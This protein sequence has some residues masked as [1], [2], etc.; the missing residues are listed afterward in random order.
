[1]KNEK[2]LFQR[3][4]EIFSLKRLVW[5]TLISGLFLVFYTPHLKFEVDVVSVGEGDIVLANYNT[6]R[7][8]E[9]F[10]TYNY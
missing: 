10:E 6:D 5:F 8:E 4:K 9:I 3:L 2:S 7:G 1:M